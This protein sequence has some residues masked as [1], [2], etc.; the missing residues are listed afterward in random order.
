MDRPS[1]YHSSPRGRGTQVG[2]FVRLNPKIQ[3][4]SDRFEIYSN[5][6]I[7]IGRSARL[8]QYEIPDPYVSNTHIRIYTIIFDQDVSYDVA[9][10]VYAEDLSRNGTLLNG[11]LMGLGNG[12]FLLRQGDVLSITR[13]ISIRFHSATYVSDRCFSDL[14]SKEIQQFR[15]QYLVTPRVLGFGAYG[16]VHMSVQ[17][18]TGRQFACKMI[19][20]KARARGSDDEEEDQDQDSRF[21]NSGSLKPT[22]PRKAGLDKMM[23][24]RLERNQREARILANLSHPNII[25]LKKA[26]RSDNTMYIISELLSGGDLFSFIK[27][28]GGRLEDLTAAAITHQVLLAVEYLHDQNIIH[29][30]IKPDN[31]MLTSLKVGTRVVL[32]DFGCAKVIDKSAKRTTT[33][34]GTLE[35]CAPEVC[36]S[37]NRGYTKAIDLWSLGCVT[38]VIVAGYSPF[39]EGKRFGQDELDILED[40]LISLG[41]SEEATDFIYRLL[42]LDEVERMDV[43]QA[44]QHGWFTNPRYQPMLDKLYQRAI[45]DWVP[46]RD[47]SI[48]VDLQTKTNYLTIFRSPT[49]GPVFRSEPVPIC[50]PPSVDH[51]SESSYDVVSAASTPAL[52]SPTLTNVF[53]FDA[54]TFKGNQFTAFREKPIPQD[55]DDEVRNLEQEI[56][57]SPTKRYKKSVFHGPKRHEIDQ[58]LEDRYLETAFKMA[59][60]Q[61]KEEIGLKLPETLA[62]AKKYLQKGQPGGDSE[63]IDRSMS[64]PRWLTV[65][66]RCDRS[67]SESKIRSIRNKAPMHDEKQV[68]KRDEVYEEFHNPFTGKKRRYI[69]G[70]D[71]ESIIAMS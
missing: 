44:L 5:E 34:V 6:E 12:G 49:Q 64:Q 52:E 21:F 8:C 35:Y 31:I 68:E 1:A 13:D 65:G 10:L 14:Q 9:P 58:E 23:K 63:A 3:Q 33:V 42:I 26:F 70:R 55:P 36:R 53:R 46:R 50:R 18:G 56:D 60:F 19:N 24:D 16:R 59:K 32:T 17:E 45:Q 57:E 25:A 48:I 43:K 54:R 71:V 7:I 20:L 38:T 4:A 47:E 62:L 67:P 29:R 11:H 28:K 37:N 61:V 41:A 51:I 27:Y 30:D 40:E 15:H 66:T 69:Y 39:D 2:T 22:K